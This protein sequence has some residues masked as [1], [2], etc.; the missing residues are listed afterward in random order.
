M[1]HFFSSEKSLDLSLCRRITL[2]HLCTTGINRL[3]GM[4]LRR[5]GCTAAAVTSCSSAEQDDDIAR[6]RSQSLYGT[7]WGSSH[8]CTNL[9]TFCYI[10]R[11]ID[12]LYITGCKTNLVTIGAVTVCRS[13]YQ[14]FLWQFALHRI[15]YGNR[16]VCCSGYTHCLVYISTSGK[17]VADCAAQTCCRTAEGFDFGRVVVGF[18]FEKYEPFLGDRTIAVVHNDRAGID[19]LRL[20]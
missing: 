15:F 5:T 8:H 6:T 18:I 14:F 19:F 13:A 9:H 3:C 20:L 1:S 2:L 11:M 17:R 7:S 10:V 16:R 12:L 4:C